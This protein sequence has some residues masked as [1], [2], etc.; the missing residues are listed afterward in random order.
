MPWPHPIAGSSRFARNFWWVARAN[1]LA[2]ALPLLAAPL[3]TRLLAPQDFGALA[4]FAALLSVL[5]SFATL[6]FDWSIPNA[7]SR[8]LAAALF[9]WGMAVLA[10]S[11]LLVLVG[12]FAAINLFQ[13]SSSI[14]TLGSTLWLLPM[15]L[16]GAGSIQMLVSWH[17]RA[18]ELAGVGRSKITQS[19]GNVG[20]ST[21]LA[22]LLPAGQGVW[23]LVLGVVA[24]S[25]IGLRPLWRSASDLKQALGLLTRRRLAA[26]RL[27]FQTEVGWSVV[28]STLSAASFA[29][30]PL[31][32]ARHFAVA[33]VG[34]FALMQ[35]VA[36]GPVS[37]VGNAVSQ[38]FWSEAARLVKEDPGALGRLYAASTRRL[39]WFALPVCSLALLGPWYVGPLFG[40]DQWAVAG[41]VLA[42]CV[43]MIFGQ[44]VVSPLSHLVIHRRQHW[45]AAWDVGRLLALVATIELLGR[46]NASIVW[47][48]FGVSLVMAVMYLSLWLLNIRALRTAG[49]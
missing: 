3:L 17:V 16:M 30:V 48:V 10:A 45:Q 49:C 9:A 37:L 42:A 12:V 38:S 47:T 5:L 29:I 18:A 35:R 15:A 4:V 46:S 7:K 28:V 19:C 39:F 25:W 36:L 44:V 26:A 23:A 20:L 41:W 34:F 14:N 2:Q 43:P 33:E 24:G 1:V 22:W 6:R 13:A 31:M 8:P 11:T 27:R 21:L 40:S 32:L